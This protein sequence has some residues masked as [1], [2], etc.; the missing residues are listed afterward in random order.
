MGM[1]CDGTEVWRDTAER[2]FESGVSYQ[3]GHRP[4]YGDD[5]FGWEHGANEEESTAGIDVGSRRAEGEEELG[6]EI[7]ELRQTLL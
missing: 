2:Y 7:A 4:E 5:E 6:E 3:F 1:Q